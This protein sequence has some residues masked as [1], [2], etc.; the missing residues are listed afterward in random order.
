MWEQ[1]LLHNRVWIH[2]SPRIM[3]K[4]VQAVEAAQFRGIRISPQLRYVPLFS[5]LFAMQISVLELWQ[6]FNSDSPPH[7]INIA[8]SR[9]S[10]TQHI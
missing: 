10:T 5:S 8:Y 4:R 6:A 3:Q 2:R 9:N 1:L 7:I